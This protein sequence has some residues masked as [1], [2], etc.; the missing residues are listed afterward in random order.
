MITRPNWPVHT[1]DQIQELGQSIP[2]LKEAKKTEG[3][4]FGNM[5]GNLV[6]DA[7][8]KQK[9]SMDI[10]NR[11]MAGEDIPLHQAVIASEEAGVSFRLMVEVRNR[12]LEAYQEMMRMQV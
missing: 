12:L 2:G 6:Q 4:N 10:T 5:L 7:N 3:P 1:R 8:A 11:V 9:A